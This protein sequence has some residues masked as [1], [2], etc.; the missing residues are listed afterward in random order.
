[1]TE[2]HVMVSLPIESTPVHPKEQLVHVVCI[3]FPTATYALLDTNN[4]LP[5]TTLPLPCKTHPTMKNCAAHPKRRCCPQPKLEL[6]QPQSRRS[7][8]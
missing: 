1:M 6:S 3:D 4:M 8:Q 5:T 7:K 2:G